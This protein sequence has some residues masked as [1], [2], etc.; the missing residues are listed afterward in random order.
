MQRTL[1]N[2]KIQQ[3]IKPP[4]KKAKRRHNPN[5]YSTIYMYISSSFPF[6]VNKV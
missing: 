3:I 5:S 4:E 2:S 6:N 1:S